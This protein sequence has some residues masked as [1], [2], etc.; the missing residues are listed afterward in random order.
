MNHLTRV[1]TNVV[2]LL[3]YLELEYLELH[4]VMNRKYKCPRPIGLY[5]LSYQRRV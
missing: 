1:V 2:Q 3:E 4:G 5:G